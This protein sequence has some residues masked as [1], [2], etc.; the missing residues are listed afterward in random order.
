MLNYVWYYFRSLNGKKYS[1]LNLKCYECLQKQ[2]DD[3]KSNC[4]PIWSLMFRFFSSIKWYFFYNFCRTFGPALQHF[5]SD[6]HKKCPI[7][8]QVRRIST[9]LHTYD[10]FYALPH[11]KY[12]PS[13]CSTEQ[14]LHQILTFTGNH[15]TELK[16]GNPER[17][18]VNID[19]RSWT[20]AD[21]WSKKNVGF[22][23]PVKFLSDLTVGPTYFAKSV[24]D[25][26]I[27]RN[28]Y[29]GGIY[30]GRWPR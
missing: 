2:R 5:L 18:S 17:T 14:P 20:M 29:E 4:C 24:T 19:I 21:I 13:S 23:G 12:W 26:Y 22:I 25:R 8:R 9:P 11:Q 10:S 27:Q 3:I 15:A 1:I 7:V 30:S 28:L 6:I 16:W